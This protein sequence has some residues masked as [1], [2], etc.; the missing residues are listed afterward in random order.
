MGRV[1]DEWRVLLFVVVM[2]RWPRRQL[3]KASIWGW[4]HLGDG[5]N[6]GKAL[7][8]G[9]LQLGEGPHA[10]ACIT[11]DASARAREGRCT[12]R[13]RSFLRGAW[14]EPPALALE[15]AVARDASARS[16]EGRCTNRQRSRSGG[17]W[18][19]PLPPFV[20]S[21]SPAQMSKV[22]DNMMMGIKR[23]LLVTSS[24]FEVDEKR[25]GVDD[26]APPKKFCDVNVAQLLAGVL[27]L[28]EPLTPASVKL[29]NNVEEMPAVS[30]DP[31]VVAQVFYQILS[32][33]VKF[34]RNGNVHVTSCVDAAASQ[35]AVSITDTGCGMTHDHVC[36]LLE[37]VSTPGEKGGA[38][39]IAD[40][41]C[42][43]T[44]DHVCQLLE[45]VSAPGKKSAG[46]SRQRA[47]RQSTKPGAGWGARTKAKILLL[48]ASRFEV[49]GLHNI[50]GLGALRFGEMFTTCLSVER[51]NCVKPEAGSVVWCVCCRAWAVGRGLLGGIKLQGWKL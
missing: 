46:S 10:T 30:A 7:T 27:K 32:N 11:M 40:T 48:G 14:R 33:A 29:I 47:G 1:C 9:R 34:T 44:R 20:P 24:F 22:I 4:C 23:T 41:G 45:D 35:I 25:A 28:V 37:D 38:V 39:S 18:R 21:A 36:Q 2:G 50:L 17:A 13:Q 8:W 43:M 51:C 12:N 5:V 6:F 3:G 42:G 15:R 31:D 26:S 16:L 49:E 19:E